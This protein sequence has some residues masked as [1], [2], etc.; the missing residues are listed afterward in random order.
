LEAV[1]VQ[2]ETVVPDPEDRAV[3]VELIIAV[4]VEVREHRV[5]A[6]T[7]ALLR[8]GVGAAAVAAAL[9]KWDK[10]DL[11]AEYTVMVV[12]VRCQI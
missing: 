10:T 9:V 1:V 8:L 11:T 4:T 2:P 12:R 3:V 5:K 6:I 7:V